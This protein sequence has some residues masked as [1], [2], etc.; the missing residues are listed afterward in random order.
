MARPGH[1]IICFVQYSEPEVD[2]RSC[3]VMAALCSSKEVSPKETEKI[4]RSKS[5]EMLPMFIA[6]HIDRHRENSGKKILS[7]KKESQPIE[8]TLKKGLK[9]QEERYLSADDIYS[10]VTDKEFV[11]KSKCR[12]S[13]K[14][15]FHL[16]QVSIPGLR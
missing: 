7:S 4:A 3:V 12:A 8:K 6:A 5:L 14:R 9:F 13:M 1:A 15:E 10:R 2:R 16:Q 11:L